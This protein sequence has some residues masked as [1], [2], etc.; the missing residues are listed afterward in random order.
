MYKLSCNQLY[1]QYNNYL[2]NLLKESGK[3]AKLLTIRVGE[4]LGA[5]SYEKSLI[6][7]C[8]NLGLE[9]ETIILQENIEE[10][11]VIS[12]IDRANEDESVNGI[13]IFQ[14]M[15][16][17]YDKDYV[18][19]RIDAKKD[20]DGITFDNKSKILELKDKRNIPATASAIHHF[21]KSE[22]EDITGKD[23][24]IINRSHIIGI[25]LFFLLEK[26]NATVTVAHS[27][28]KN[29][30]GLM[31]DKDIIITAVGKS[32]IFKPDELKEG[33]IIIDM[34]ISQN[35]QGKY[36]GDMD[37]ESIKDKN[38]G[39]MPSIGGIGKITRNI[40]I[41]NTTINSLGEDYGR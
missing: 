28:S 13:L 30:E 26:D 32:E 38:I 9:I 27:R 39:Y 15:L 19:Q 7:H 35:A 29:I 10:E 6:K 17:D 1:D 36:T 12:C 40:I 37:L 23:V 5:I 2:K 34:G 21:I 20:V 18:L 24:L 41:E 11:K 22:L 14:P 31:K 8:Q 25:P 16:G 33:A 3:K 4:D